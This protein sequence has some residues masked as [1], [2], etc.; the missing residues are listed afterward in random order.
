M[1][2][3]VN[4]EWLES[5]R[6]ALANVHAEQPCRASLVACQVCTAPVAGYERCYKCNED[7]NGPYGRDLADLVAP[8][9]YAWD[10][11]SQ[12][13]KDVYSYKQAD[14]QV[15]AS[16]NGRLAALVYTFGAQH[17]RCPERFLGRAVTAKALVPSLRGNPGTQLARLADRFLPGWARIP[18]IAAI[19]VHDSN[20]RRVLDP[21]HFAVEPGM[22]PRMRTCSSSKTA[23]SPGDTASQSPS[24]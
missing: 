20:A 3:P 1:S 4:L 13:G 22:C 23:G 24:P 2:L 6:L 8:L 16:A 7:R 14:A 12:L 19:T 9:A 18:V 21:S 15:A 5:A 11:Q 10:G 17:G